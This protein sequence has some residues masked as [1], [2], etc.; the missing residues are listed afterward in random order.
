MLF[1]TKK[2]TVIYVILMIGLVV[3][4]LGLTILYTNLNGKHVI[5]QGEFEKVSSQVDSLRKTV[6]LVKLGSNSKLPYGLTSQ[7][8]YDLVEPSIVKITV[9]VKRSYGLVPY[10]QGSGFIFSKDGFIV[11]N[12]HVVMGADWIGVTFLEGTIETAEFVGA[13]PYS[14]LA[15]IKVNPA[16]QNLQQLFVGNS[17]LLEVGDPV[18]AIGNPFGLSGSMSE[19]I[20]SQLDRTLSTQYGYLIVG[21]IQTDAAINPGN[22]GGPLLNKWGEVV[23]VNSAIASKSGDFSGVGFA[24]P[25]N[26]MARV[27]SSLIKQ[28]SYT[29]PWLGLAGVDV[30]PDIVEAMDLNL[31]RGFLLTYVAPNSPVEKAGIKVGNK[32]VIIDGKRINVGGDI[33]IGIDDLQVRKLEDLLVFIEY[34]RSPNDSVMLKIIRENEVMIVEVELE[35]R[36]PPR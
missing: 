10:A 13:D 11:T 17:S 2:W 14:D 25:S 29:H 19:G 4:M 6:D 35:E 16:I 9:K 34:N 32:T 24:I 22:S 12:H 23:G 36:P 31:S 15:V 3:S 5:L 28:G 1:S 7:Q 21:V 8:I 20:V 30:T 27:V 33:I 18:F 26:L